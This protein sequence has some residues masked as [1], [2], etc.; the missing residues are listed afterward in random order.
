MSK[1]FDREI[2][3][4]L[5]SKLKD[6]SLNGALLKLIRSYLCNR[7]LVVCFNGARSTLY[8]ASSGVPQGSSLGLL[9]FTLITND[10]PNALRYSKCLLYTNDYKIFRSLV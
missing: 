6:F 5:C 1:S 3:G 10:L 4:F 8:I 9:L 7:E 2:H